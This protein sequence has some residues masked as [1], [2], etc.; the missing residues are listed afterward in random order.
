MKG[1]IT[2][3][4]FAL[5]CLIAGAMQQ[6]SLAA[7][8]HVAP[9]T[10]IAADGQCSLIEAFVNAENNSPIHADCPAG[11]GSDR[12]VLAAGHTY[13]LNQPFG[14]SDTGLPVLTDDLGLY[15]RDAMITRSSSLP[16]YRLLEL[17]GGK[18]LI[19]D[20]VLLRGYSSGIMQGGGAIWVRDHA[21]VR[22][23]NVTFLG[24]Q[25]DGLFGFGGAVRIDNSQVE[26]TDSVFR[27]NSTAQDA[28]YDAGGAAIAQIEGNLELH[29]TSFIDNT[30][31]LPCDPSNPNT[32]AGT[33]GALMVEAWSDG[34]QTVISDSTLSG[35]TGRIGG[36]IHVSALA[37]TGA[38]PMDI[39]VEIRRS[40]IAENDA[41]SCFFGGL[42]DGIYV[43]QANGGD[44]LVAY[45]N[46]IVLG[47]GHLAGGQLIGNDCLSNDPSQD[48]YS[49]FG[50]ILDPDDN[51]TISPYD[52]PAGEMAEILE[53]PINGDHYRPERHSPAVDFPYAAL[54]CD[55][56]ERDQLGN[57]RAG[58]IAHGGDDCDAGAVEL[59]YPKEH[60]VLAVTLTGNGT[61]NV[62]SD[63][64][65]LVCPGNCS[66]EAP[67]HE[68]ELEARPR[69]GSVFMGWGGDCSGTG[70]CRVD[71]RQ[72]RSV[73][74]E[75]ARV[76]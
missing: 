2:T 40:T 76:P 3:R 49:L 50:N 23:H 51:C 29:R 27:G 25:A 68:V 32:S 34:A 30:A 37:D 28:G 73:V 62:M 59:Q 36:A 16:A 4:M 7:D 57:V 33:G 1:R 15:G 64:A 8:L 14:N 75:F 43:Q 21:D 22:I 55:L 17:A 66:V 48:Y 70:I 5:A 12:V 24:N 18:F 72:N 38:L 71:M 10:V 54:N 52:A 74:A 44:G 41:G 61:G 45:G 6:V 60:P 67:G 63:P 19:R 31:V 69:S 9:V 20:L 53:L 46:T 47:N 13:V 65:G 35:N 58:G 26:I 39:Y 42:G 11:N 56:S